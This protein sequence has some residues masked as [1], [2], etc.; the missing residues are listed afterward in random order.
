VTT[1]ST[2]PPS[3][4]SAEVAQR[5]RAV[6]RRIEEA[7]GDPNR[8]RIVGVTKGFRPEAVRAARKQKNAMTK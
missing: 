4:A 8:V 1:I 6:R 3:S 5:L 7:G 2:S